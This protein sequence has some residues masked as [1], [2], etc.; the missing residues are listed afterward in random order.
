MNLAGILL[1]TLI[2]AVICLVLPKLLSKISRYSAPN[3]QI[4][5]LESKLKVVS[6]FPYCATYMLTHNSF[7]KF[8]PNF[9]H[10]CSMN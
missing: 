10:R 6:S 4:P 7:C 5:L 3:P 1:L 2:N 8:S 9:C